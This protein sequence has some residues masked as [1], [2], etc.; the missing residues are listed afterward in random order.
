MPAYWLGSLSH[1]L[2][3][4]P[5]V[6]DGMHYGPIFHVTRGQ[7]HADDVQLLLSRLPACHYM[8]QVFPT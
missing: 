2:T 1:R 3:V 7:P 5:P 6:I 4:C 8:N